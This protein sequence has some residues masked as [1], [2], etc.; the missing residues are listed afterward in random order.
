MLQAGLYAEKHSPEN[1]FAGEEI[2]VVDDQYQ[3]VIHKDE[4]GPEVHPPYLPSKRPVP[5]PVRSRRAGQ[6]QR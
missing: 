4:A 1:A 6:S 5:I 2:D 3:N